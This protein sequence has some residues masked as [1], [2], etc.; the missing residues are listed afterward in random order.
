ILSFPNMTVAKVRRRYLD[1][2]AKRGHAIIPSASL[3]PENDPTTLF[4]SS[5]MQPLVP[6]L[7]GQPHPQGARLANSQLS[8]R[9][10]DIEEVGDNRHT[11]FFE[12]LGNWSLGDY[13][14]KEQLLW[15]YEFL[16]EELKLPKERLWVTCFAGDETHGLPK[17]TESAEIWRNIGMPDERILFYDATKNWWSRS[18][19]PEKMPAGEPGGPDS[20]IFYEFTSVEH[21]LAFSEKCHPNCD[22]GHFMEIGNSVF[23]EYV[24]QADG[25]FGKLPKQNVDFGGGL[26]R[27]TAATLDTPD[28]FKIDIFDWIRT[29]LEKIT[30]KKYG[31]DSETTRIF[32]IVIDHVRAS[33]FIMAAGVKPSN[34]EQGYIL[35][36]LLRRSMLFI[37]KLKQ[38]TSDTSFFSLGWIVENFAN[39]Y[40]DS[41]PSLDLKQEEIQKLIVMEEN[42]FNITLAQG[43]RELEKMGNYIDAFLLFTT[44]GFPIELTAEIAKERGLSI[45]LADVQKKMNEH[46]ALSRAGAA[47]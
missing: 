3:V 24:K 20:E 40:K 16:T 38:N 45:D 46:Q 5:G 26:E 1:F 4:T 35:R 9:A 13:F 18:G 22:C 32:R 27:L 33:L 37:N 2:F 15:I 43:M 7:L 44:Y 8:F 6:Y 41:Y 39:V 19:T 25:S 42:S 21:D 23:M 30:G 36:R 17:D 14:K 10:G 47:Q 11:T 12:M 34:T 31:E 29:N 28:I